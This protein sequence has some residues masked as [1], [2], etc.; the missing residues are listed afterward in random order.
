MIEIGKLEFLKLLLYRT[1][2]NQLI[3]YHPSR[4]RVKRFS[5]FLPEKVN[6]NAQ[7]LRIQTINIVSHPLNLLEF[8]VQ[9]K[10]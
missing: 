7:F 2:P 4:K 1:K 6:K 9:F 3:F 10:C 5:R 8:M